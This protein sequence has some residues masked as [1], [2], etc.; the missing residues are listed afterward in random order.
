MTRK[1]L[2]EVQLI[3]FSDNITLKGFGKEEYSVSTRVSGVV[4]CKGHQFIF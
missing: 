1:E 4:G 2:R 3:R